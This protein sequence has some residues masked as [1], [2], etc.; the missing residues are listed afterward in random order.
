MLSAGWASLEQLIDMIYEAAVLPDRW[1]DVLNHLS[2]RFGAKG[3]VLFTSSLDDVRWLGAGESEQTFADW[4]A[5]GWAAKNDRVPRLLKMNYPGFITDW[6][7]YSAEEIAASPMYSEFLVPRGYIAAAGTAI[8][9]ATGDTLIF[10]VEGFPAEHQARQ[11]FPFMDSIRPHLAR[12]AMLS[13]QLHLE[14]ARAAV[15]ALELVGA[16]AAF[17]GDQGTLLA[18]NPRFQTLLGKDILDYRKSLRFPD[19]KVDGL[20][21]AA[22]HK[23]RADRTGRSIPMSSSETRTRGI[24]H[25][26]PICGSARDI[27]TSGGAILVVAGHS[28]TAGL[29]QELL[30]GLFDLT[31]A[32]ARLARALMQGLTPAGAA[33]KFALSEGTIRSQLKALFAK[34]GQSR[35]SELVRMLASF[36]VLAS[37]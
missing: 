10:S 35:Q 27:F 24:L 23:V 22:L 31:P 21:R 16:P 33:R 30:Q 18:A 25:V 1:A 6:D 7:L 11:A 26:V 2:D 12:A 3:G 8:Q 4:V 14:R 15:T 37:S 17:V 5:Q 29:S 19:S 28:T 13:S 32:E 9:G 36:I 20:Y 34:T